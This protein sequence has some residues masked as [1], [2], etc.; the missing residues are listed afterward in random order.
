[1]FLVRDGGVG[2]GVTNIVNYLRKPNIRLLTGKDGFIAPI[3]SE[4]K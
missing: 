2:Y 3:I 4:G 1:M